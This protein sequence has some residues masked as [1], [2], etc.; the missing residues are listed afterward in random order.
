MRE[1]DVY[2]YL[3]RQGLYSDVVAI[4][5]E[6]TGYG[7]ED[8]MNLQKRDDHWLLFYVGRGEHQPMGKFKSYEEAL[9]FIVHCLFDQAITMLCAAFRFKHF[10]ELDSIPEPGEPWPDGV[11]RY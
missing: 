6:N 4:V 8:K 1:S 3:I 5:P 2:E 9:K 7:Y 10:P 11:V